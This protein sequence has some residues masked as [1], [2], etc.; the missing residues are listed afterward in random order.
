MKKQ[1]MRFIRTSNG[2]T[3]MEFAFP[4]VFIDFN[5]N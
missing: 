3:A 1:V 4:E 5:E 2:L